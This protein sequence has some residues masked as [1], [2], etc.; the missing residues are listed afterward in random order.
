MI[1]FLIVWPFV[2]AALVKFIS[3]CS[4]RL[5]EPSVAAV[6]FIQ[7]AFAA[8]L[9]IKVY[10]GGEIA[11]SPG[12]L[13][14][15]KATFRAD[16]FRAL[17]ACVA[18]FMWFC[19]ALMS[20]QYFARYHNRTRYYFFCFLTLGGVTGMLLSDDL[21]TAFIFFEIMSMAS[22]PWVAHE[23]TEGAMRAAATYLGIAVAGGM[24]TLMGMML[25]YSQTGTLA[26][27]ALGKAAH[28]SQV[29]VSGVLILF[30]F[31]AKAGAFPLHIWLPK[32]HP[33]APAPASALLSGL[34][35]KAGIFGVLVVSFSIFRGNHVYGCIL[36]GIALVTMLL[37]AVL[38]VFSVN[39]KRTLACSSMSQIGYILTG[40]A[41]SV[42]LGEEGTLPLGGS[43]AHMLNHS[44]LKLALFMTAGAI[45]MNAHTLDLNR[46]QGYGRK[47]P[48]LHA[49]YL[50]GALGLSGVPLFNG[51]VSKTMIHE[52]LVEWVNESGLFVFRL[53]EWVFLFA[54]GLTAAYMLKTYICLFWQRNADSELQKK[55]D[56]QGRGYLDLLTRAA[57]IL[58]A[59]LIP[60]FGLLPEFTLSRLAEKCLSF[61]GLSELESIRFFSLENLKGGA[62][63]LVIGTLVYLFVVRKWMYSDKDGY[64]D[65][66]PQ[67]LDLE[68]L[69]YRPLLCRLIPGFMAKLFAVLNCTGDALAGG[70]VRFLKAVSGAIEPVG[71]RLAGTFVRLLKLV[72]GAIEPVGDR[73]SGA[74]T[75]LIALVSRLLECVTDCAALFLRELL[76]VDHRRDRRGEVRGFAGRLRSAAAAFQSRAEKLKP[77]L[78][79]DPREVT[80]LTYGSYFTNTITFGLIVATLGIVIALVYIIVKNR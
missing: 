27:D 7:L 21:F 9:M 14:G 1:L 31:L 41:S 11:C 42:L 33:V 25:L 67:R 40:V 13:C 6:A 32:A 78:R 61:T 51:Y 12:E 56:A 5:R 53:C 36:L 74:L 72:S 64:I 49:V 30:G 75:A 70:F 39:L 59:V 4:R 22:Y 3:K 58:S 47:K 63:T 18:A 17:Y 69:V 57:L 79:P 50:L 38:G 23:E 80:D 26:F 24:V 77:A 46:L 20:R 28:S 48:L 52:G 43:F 62:V 15:L 54:A 44:V 73:L 55:Y 34:L 60:L 29:Y 76:F 19:T 8:W 37:G 2:G 10:T 45:Y 35:T 66:W 71:D 68:E 16:G 65:R